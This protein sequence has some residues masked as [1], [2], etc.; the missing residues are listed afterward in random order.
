MRL[1]VVNHI[2]IGGGVTTSFLSALQMIRNEGHEAIA[3]VPKNFQYCDAVE[4]KASE[5]FYLNGFERGGHL[6][7]PMQGLKIA[8]AAK[9][10]NADRI[11]VNNGRHVRWVKAFQ[12]RPI[13]C[14]YHGGKY[15]KVDRIL[16]ADKVI[17]VNDEQKRWLIERGYPSEK[18]KVIDNVL[19]MDELPEW[20]ERSFSSPIT[21]GT[22]RL[23]EPAKGVD[24]LIDATRLL[25]RKNTKFQVLIG[26]DGSQRQLLEERTRKYHLDKKIKFIGWVDKPAGFYNCLD[27]Y[28]MPSRFETWGLGIAEAQAH[29]LPVIATDCLGPARLIQNGDNGLLVPPNDPR[30]I[31][32]AINR[33]MSSPQ[34]AKKLAKSGHESAGRYL[35]KN[36]QDTY[37]S[38]LTDPISKLEK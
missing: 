19:P 8:R 21:I 14:I 11:V 24:T 4:S 26:G 12:K 10:C 23:L 20:R 28:V 32:D 6:S 29:S 2:A 34:L 25:A 22:L 16:N 13:I 38:F 17:T 9:E 3:L 27:L 30:A 35:M 18:V 15:E 37:V 1:L 5:T 33:L 36:I 31:A 7:F